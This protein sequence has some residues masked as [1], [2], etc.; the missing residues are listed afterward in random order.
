MGEILRIVAPGDIRFDSYE[1]P[2][3]RPGQVRIRTLYSGISAGTELTHFRGTNPMRSRAWDPA[4]RLFAPTPDP[5]YYPRATGYEEVG[6]VAEVGREVRKVKPG[7]VVFGTWTHRSSWIMDEAGAVENTLPSGLAPV[8]GIFSQIGSIALNG[9]LD[10]G[11][12]LREWVAI[13]GMGT[14]GLICAMLARLSGARVIAID[15]HDSRLALA[16][17]FGAEV[18]LRAGGRP[19]AEAIRDA[20]GGGADICIEVS[21]STRALHDAIKA[22]AY[23]AT[24]VAMGFYQGEAQGLFLGEEF[25]HN[26]IR[27]VSSQI[28]GIQPGLS[29]RWSHRRLVRT[30]MELQR[31]GL[32]P[33]EELIT[34]R[35][36]F[37]RAHEIYRLIDTDP[38]A[39]LQAVL[40]FPGTPESGE[41]EAA[42]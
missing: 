38:A 21:G 40:C 1:E 12:R 16:R 42:P 11:I 4:R 22:A 20:T 23:Q 33:L 7:D 5:S 25:H 39:V 32:L 36:P 30:V 29:A 24:V 18:V 3:L 41:P 17:R 10:A 19:A 27:L 14:P 2:E 31:D 28:G 37:R 35:V 26:R 15:L 13:F 6:K 8:L 34:H 9:V